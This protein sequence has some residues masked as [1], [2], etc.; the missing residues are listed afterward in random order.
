MSNK[1]LFLA[2]MMVGLGAA[3]SA[4]PWYVTGDVSIGAGGFS[5]GTGAPPAGTA[6]DLRLRDDGTMGDAVASDGIF[7]VQ[8]TGLTPSATGSWKVATSG[9]TSVTPTA[10]DNYVLTVPGSGI[11]TYFLDTNVQGDDFVPDSGSSNTPLGLAYTDTTT[12]P[13]RVSAATTVSLVGAMQDELAAGSDWDASNT[14]LALNDAGTGGDTSAADGIWTIQ[15]TGLPSGSYDYKIVLDGAFG[16]EEIGT[17]GYATGGGNLS[18]TS[19]DVANTI[20]IEFDTALCGRTKTDNPAVSAGPPFF[21][22]SSAWGTGFGSLENMGAAVG[23]V[24]S[25]VFTVATAGTYSVRVRQGIGRAFP[26]TGDYPFTTTSSPQDV[27]VVLDR[28]SYGDGFEPASDFVV[29]LD[30]ATRTPLNSFSKVQPV[31][32]WQDD[33]GASEWD[34]NVAL[35]DLADDGN[36]PDATAGDEIYTGTFTAFS[37]STGENLKAVAQRAGG[38]DTD[39]DVQVG[40]P[41]DGLTVSGNNSNIS[42]DYAAGDVTFVVDTATG[43]MGFAAGTAPAAPTRAS[44]FSTSSGVSDWMVLDN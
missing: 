23:D 30:D 40:G 38:T 14:T 42:F 37:G 24:Y 15:L 36:A 27:L 32:S 41:N 16:P 19:L 6:D 11:V 3:V 44:Y 13:D 9:F 17:A 25:K 35:L 26:D 28:N 43:R 34:A 31:G 5:P 2:A 12:I 21:A 10:T 29:V 18:M 7:S 39:F 8:V 20:T 22:Q 33:F 1:T 4:Q